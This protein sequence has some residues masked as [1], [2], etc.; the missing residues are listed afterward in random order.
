MNG[1]ASD[2]STMTA[3]LRRAR[4]GGSVRSWLSMRRESRNPEGDNR[5]QIS[6]SPHMAVY[7]GLDP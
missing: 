5:L 6:D 4:H 1:L 2:S 3:G 7:V